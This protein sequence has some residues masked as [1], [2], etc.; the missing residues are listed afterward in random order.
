MNSR[1]HT[2]D[3]LP[4]SPPPLGSRR[5]AEHRSRKESTHTR[6]RE[7]RR[8]DN[9]GVLIQVYGEEYCRFCQDAKRLVKKI[10]RMFE[11]ESNKHA[12]YHP[13]MNLS[14]EERGQIGDYKFIPI[15]FVHQKWIGGFNKLKEWYNDQIKGESESENESEN[16]SEYESESESESEV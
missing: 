8:R 2:S 12:E 14:E 3:V 7:S 4:T 5:D 1:H 15:V 10:N 13:M 6:P 11:T 16:E 9:T